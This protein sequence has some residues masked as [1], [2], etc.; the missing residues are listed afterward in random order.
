ELTAQIERAKELGIPISHLDTHMGALVSRPDLI[1]VYVSLGLKYDLPIL[2]VRE[3]EGPIVEAYPALRER[4][5]QWLASLD[6]KGLPVLDGLAQFYGGDSHEERVEN[7]METLR[8]LPP[9][10]S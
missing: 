9:G 1:E 3:V 6:A 7:Y 10:V 4:G 8:N 5:K 2:F